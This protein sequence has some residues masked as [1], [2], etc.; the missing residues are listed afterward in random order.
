MPMWSHSDHNLASLWEVTHGPSERMLELLSL[1]QS[2]ATWQ[3]AE[4]A[5]RLE[6]SPRTLRRDIERLRRLGYPVLS[7]RGPGGSY[8]LVAGRAMPPLLLTDDEATAMVVGL[9]F[10][11]VAQVDGA[12]VAADA[13]LRKLEQVL[14]SRLRHRV[15]ALLA[16]T[17]TAS[18]TAGAL[19]LGTL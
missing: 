18:R 13:A 7:A 16:S 17:E 14:P 19:D 15:R 10:A 9:R 8:R 12:T 4:L 1:L 11:S 2:G 5:A 3:G 6:T